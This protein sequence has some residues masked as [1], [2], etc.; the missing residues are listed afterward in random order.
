MCIYLLNV[1]LDV[2]RTAAAENKW[3]QLY[4]LLEELTMSDATQMLH[5]STKQYVE[6]QKKFALGK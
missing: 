5:D 1:T 4:L 2:V 3:H 6:E